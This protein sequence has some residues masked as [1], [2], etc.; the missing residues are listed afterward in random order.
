MTKLVLIAH[1]WC[2]EERTAQ[3][4]TAGL[5]VFDLVGFSSYGFWSGICPSEY[6]GLGRKSQKAVNQGGSNL[7]D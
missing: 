5:G 6:G 4:N 2:G 3:S 7:S 1:L